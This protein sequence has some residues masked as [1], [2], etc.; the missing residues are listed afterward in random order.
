MLIIINEKTKKN[1]KI[2]ISIMSCN[3]HITTTM[4]I[5]AQKSKEKEVK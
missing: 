3:T 1:I 5:N 2:D 4:V